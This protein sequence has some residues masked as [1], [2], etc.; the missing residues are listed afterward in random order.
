MLVLTRKKGDKVR[1]RLPDGT[2][3][4]VVLVES[5]GGRV[6]LGFDAP[7]EAEISRGELL[8]EGERH[9]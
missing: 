3:V 6:R 2:T 9:G 5:R 4:W 7:R 1:L 8:P